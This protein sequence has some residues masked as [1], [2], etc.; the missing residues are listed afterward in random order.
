MLAEPNSE[1]RIGYDHISVWN[2]D[3]IIWKLIIFIA[4]A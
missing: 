4:I 3:A 1:K 2:F